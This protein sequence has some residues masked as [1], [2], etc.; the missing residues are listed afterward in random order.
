MAHGNGVNRAIHGWNEA[1]GQHVCPK[2]EG[3]PS[4]RPREHYP[5]AG[6]KE[7]PP[8][9]VLENPGEPAH[10]HPQGGVDIEGRRGEREHG[11][12]NSAR[13][14]RTRRVMGAP[15]QKSGVHQTSTDVATRIFPRT[16]S[17]LRVHTRVRFSTLA[18]RISAK[19]R[20]AASGIDRAPLASTMSAVRFANGMRRSEPS[21]VDE[22]PTVPP[23]GRRLS[24]TVRRIAQASSLDPLEDAL[25]SRPHWDSASREPAVHELLYRFAMGDETGAL[26]AADL[27]LDSTSRPSTHQCRS[28]TSSMRSS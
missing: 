4:T 12:R 6:G 16:P 10:P 3:Q 23:S 22:H 27:L 7:R 9:A 17:R 21:R 8:R 26:T 28:S 5:A 25:L 24:G 2:S 11:A 14:T 1:Q 15:A 13:E 18:S 20:H 19:L